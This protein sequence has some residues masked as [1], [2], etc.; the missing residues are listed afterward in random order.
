MFKN[1]P[2]SLLVITALSFGIPIVV[3]PFLVI[4]NQGPKPDVVSV[5]IPDVEYICSKSGVEY[6]MT[7]T[8]IAV[9]VYD[10]G[11]PVKCDRWKGYTNQ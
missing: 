4:K 1:I 11:K 9:H 10:D 8:G 2:T 6:L 3:I 5:A 7:N